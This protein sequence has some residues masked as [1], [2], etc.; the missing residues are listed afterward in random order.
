M[1]E[2]AQVFCSDDMSVVDYRCKLG[3]GDRP[4]PEV[5]KSF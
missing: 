3:P 2:A 4:F 1:G 5:H